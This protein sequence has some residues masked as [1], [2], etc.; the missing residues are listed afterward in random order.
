MSV[1]RTIICLLMAALSLSAAPER[2][3]AGEPFLPAGVWYGGG[4]VQPPAVARD[5]T[6]DRDAWRRDLA[7]I[8]ALGFNSITTWVDWAA[9][10]PERGTY[11]F[12]ALTQSLSLADEVGLKV[13]VHVYTDAAP[14]WLGR[15]YA[16][17][18]FDAGEPAGTPGSSIGGF[19]SDHPGVRDDLL[20]FIDAATRAAARHE[21]FYAIELRSHSFIGGSRPVTAPATLCRC[22]HTA[23][24]FHEWARRRFGQAPA[25]ASARDDFDAEK[26]QADLKQAADAARAQGARIV[27]SYSAAN[28]FPGQDGWRMAAS[29]DRYGA[30]FAPNDPEPDWTPVRLMAELDATQS[31][32]GARGWWLGELQADDTAHAADLRLWGW[33]A[34]SR[35]ARAM[36]YAGRVNPWS[37]VQP[38]AAERAKAAAEVAGT[39]T[40][41]ARLFAPMRGRPAAAAIVLSGDG[42][43]GFGAAALAFYRLMFEQNIQ[44]DFVHGTDVMAGAAAK[45]RLLFRDA[46]APL[47]AAVEAALQAYA[48]AG[49]TLIK[50]DA[51][52]MRGQD[53][54]MRRLI[55]SAG[56]TPDVRIQGGAGLV[57]ARFLESPDAWLLVA[58]NHADARQAVTLI[59]AP[60]V[61]EA[62]WQNMETGS[63]VQFIQQADGPTYRHI[64]APR[65][66]MILVRGKRLR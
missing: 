64:F 2:Q 5:P 32:A 11:D 15:R 44:C 25:G 13:I 7:A 34:Y 8:E 61:P 14:G 30:R 4:S 41:N 20:D 52:G 6:K 28:G 26:R 12:E 40:R 39:L 42:E 47:P 1:M 37:G 27:A 23:A 62:I 35:G 59:F 53:E 29:V 65:D 9:A 10:E 57:E 21:S 66:V 38:A 36:S 3:A 55:A 56:V 43:G 17:A 31:A 58:I 60:D 49:G 33:A 63:A 50:E 24:R 22:P 45:Y 16:D 19:C 18:R 48:R 51:A 46:S 54:R